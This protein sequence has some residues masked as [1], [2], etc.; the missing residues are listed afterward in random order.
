MSGEQTGT[1]TREAFAAGSFGRAGHG[2]PGLRPLSVAPMMDW[3]DRHYRYFL[4]RITRC[5]LLYTEMVTTGAIIHGDRDHL[6]GFNDDE[7]PLALQ[8]GGDDPASC[9]E[10]VR[11]AEAYGYDEYDL[12]V[13]CPSDRVQNG[14]F[15]ACLMAD[16]ERVRRIVEAMKGATEKP[17]T[18]KHRIGIN[19]RESYEELA[20]FVEHVAQA[21]ADRF[22]VHARIAVL[23]GLSPK[24][25]RNIPPLRY[26]DVYR[27]KEDFPT[28]PIEINGHV[29]SLAE[30]HEHLRRVDGVMIGRAAYDN[31]FLL[32]EADRELFGSSQPPPTRKEVAQAMIPYVEQVAAR[33]RGRRTV[34]RHMLGLFA[35]KPGARRFRRVLSDPRVDEKPAGEAIAEALSGIPQDVLDARGA[36]G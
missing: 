28:L 11:I 5:V 29:A 21:G 1:P 9:A 2:R 30:V 3:T 20:E 14:A 36:Y 25:N 24:E 10:S 13:G 7:H 6:L 4:R 22:I 16:P 26:E 32:S 19:G 17:V 18:V 23:E 33:G 8:I 31:P 34:Y 35:F 12:N 27:L 15:G